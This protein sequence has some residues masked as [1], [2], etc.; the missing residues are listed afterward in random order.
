M[1]EQLLKDLLSKEYVLLIN[2]VLA[3]QK[4][5]QEKQHDLFCVF[6]SKSTDVNKI[7]LRYE[8]KLT[9]AEVIAT[10]CK[11]RGINDLGSA[12]NWTLCDRSTNA[13]F[14]SEA[15]LE[16]TRSRDF[17]LLPKSR[18]AANYIEQE[19]KQTIT[20]TEG[21]AP[22]KLTRLLGPLFFHTPESAAEYKVSVER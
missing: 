2:P 10:V 13:A 17:M 22:S 18:Q 7:L 15:L 16:E 11:C 6:L 1:T 21:D 19:G 20:G 5:Q 9:V 3:V 4:K 8:P 14:S 12:E